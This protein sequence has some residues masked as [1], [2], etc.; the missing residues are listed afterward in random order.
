VKAPGTLHA[1]PAE[2]EALERLR[3]EGYVV[4]RDALAPNEV[5]AIHD[6]LM[7]W[8]ERTPHGRSDFEGTHTQRVYN[9]IAKLPSA[10]PLAIHPPVM[11]MA[12]AQLGNGFQLSIAQAV[13][14][15]PGETE[16]QLH[17]DDLPFPM[18]KP[19]QPVVL[20]SMWAITGFTRANG[21][22]RLVPGSQNRT[23]YPAEEECVFAEMPAGSVLVW[24]G[25]LFHGGG[26]NTTDAER[27]GLTIN[28]NA[29]WLR[30][31][32]NQY[33]AVPREMLRTMPDELKR[34]IG[35]ELFGVLG[36]VDGVHPLKSL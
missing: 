23:H 30:Q 34:L 7:P 12:R 14:I 25:S 24:D 6:E 26:A 1:S 8:F 33:L 22:T 21:A 27:L 18:P 35:Y 32:E 2:N 28:Y 11:E 5:R 15:L 10:H 16:Q 36:V 31:Q 3:R 29:A 4:L 19:H 20:N 17:T 13:R 9:L